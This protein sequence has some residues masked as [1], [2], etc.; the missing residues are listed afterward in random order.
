MTEYFLS[1]DNSCHWYIVPAYKEQDWLDWLSLNEDDEKSWE[2][3]KFVIRINGSPS[4]V[5][6][7][8]PRIT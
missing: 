3:P 5:R 8:N 2:P 4:K 7:I 6:F 1:Q